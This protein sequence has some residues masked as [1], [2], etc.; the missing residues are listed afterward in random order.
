MLFHI[1]FAVFIRTVQDV[2]VLMIHWPVYR[3]TASRNEDSLLLV[4]VK[5][6]N[7]RNNGCSW[8]PPAH[9]LVFLISIHFENSILFCFLAFFKKIYH[10]FTRPIH[11]WEIVKLVE[12]LLCR[13]ERNT[14]HD[15]WQER[16]SFTYK[17]HSSQK[18]DWNSWICSP[19]IQDTNRLM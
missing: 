6:H 1:C 15:G 12:L 9:S 3:E 16:G 13:S 19:G 11:M 8:L 14:K 5:L 17:S 18:W 10:V 4:W 2:Y 7:S